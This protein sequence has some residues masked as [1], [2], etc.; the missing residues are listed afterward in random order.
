MVIGFGRG[1]AVG[2]HRGQEI[3]RSR[4]RCRRLGGRSRRGCCGGTTRVSGDMLMIPDDVEGA[5]TSSRP[6]STALHRSASRG[7]H[8]GMGRRRGGR[9]LVDRRPG[10]RTGR[11]DG[12]PP[13][14]PGHAG[15]RKHQDL[16]RRRHLRH[17]LAVDPPVRQGP[18]TG[19]GTSTKHAPS[20]S[21]ITTRPKRCTACAR[22]TGARSRPARAWSW[23]AEGSRPIPNVQNYLASMGC[24]NAFAL[25]S[26][27]NVGDGVDGAE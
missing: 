27:Y 24:P 6:S 14:I 22:K 1:G 26:P 16:L 2:S 19:R 23:P 25:G 9:L 8:A 4:A 10:V 12:G 15:R 7:I 5:V 17:V 20:S 3:G 18:G 13:R 21:S 11:R